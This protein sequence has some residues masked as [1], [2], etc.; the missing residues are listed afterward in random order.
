MNR[1][2]WDERVPIHV[3][4]RFYDVEGFLAGRDTLQPF[5]R[6]EVGDVAGRTLVHLQCHFGQDT[7][8]WARAGARVTGLDFSPPAIGQ[9]RAMAQRIGIEAEFVEANVYDAVEALGGRQFD[10]VYAGMG[11][12]VWLPDTAGWVSVVSRLVRPGGFV[13]LADGHPIVQTL[14]DDSLTI[15]RDYFSAEPERY[16]EPGTYAQMDAA[17]VHNVTYEW[18]HSLG[19]LITGLAQSG[20]HIDFLH[21]RDYSFFQRWPFLQFRPEDGT[22]RIPPGMPSVPMTYSLRASRPA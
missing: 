14:A 3:A 4:S 21:E 5:E 10:I 22:Y 1:A 11:S 15:V 20:L 13:Y 17:T 12:L 9:A 18:R 16:D 8:S 19:D 6:D 2:S 7:L